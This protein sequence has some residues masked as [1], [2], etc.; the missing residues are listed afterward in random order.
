MFKSDLLDVLFRWFDRIL[1]GISAGLLCAS[2]LYSL[3]DQLARFAMLPMWLICTTTFIG[4]WSIRKL[5]DHFSIR[6]RRIALNPENPIDVKAWFRFPG[7]QLSV[8]IGVLVLSIF[9]VDL[10]LLT[11]EFLI[12]NSP[13]GGL[14]FFLAAGFI[15]ASCPSHEDLA[16][17]EPSC[18][19][20]SP[21]KLGACSD[22][23]FRR[24]VEQ[25][26]SE[27]G[28]DFYNRSAYIQRMVARLRDKSDSAGLRGQIL[29]GSFG[30]GKSTLLKHV[31]NN[32]QSEE[33]GTWLVSEFDCW[34]RSDEPH[35]LIRQLLSSV[36]SD[37]GSKVEATSLMTLPSDFMHAAYGVNS[38]V[39]FFYFLGRHHEPETVLIRL[40][41]LLSLQGLELLIIIEN[42]DRS[43]EFN[44][45]V[46][47]VAAMLDKAS[48]LSSIQFIFTGDQKSLPLPLVSRISDY[49]ESLSNKLDPE[50]IGRFFKLCLDHSFPREGKKPIIPYLPKNYSAT[51]GNGVLRDLKFKDD[52]EDISGLGHLNEQLLDAICILLGNPRQL[53]IVL[54][55]TYE[56]WR[57]LQGEVYIVDLLVYSVALHDGEILE[58]IQ[59][60]L[61]GEKI[62]NPFID[63]AKSK[64]RYYKNIDD[65]RDRIK[66]DS[67]HYRDIIAYYLASDPKGDVDFYSHFSV[68]NAQRIRLYGEGQDKYKYAVD[69]GHVDAYYSDQSI[70]KCLVG[71]SKGDE[72]IVIEFLEKLD[73]SKFDARTIIEE[74]NRRYW[75][76]ITPLLRVMES[77]TS[78][79]SIHDRNIVDILIVIID[80]VLN[81]NYSRDRED[82]PR[83]PSDFYAENATRTFDC[84]V[85]QLYSLVRRG[86]YFRFGMIVRDISCRDE[87]IK[88]DFSSRIVEEFTSPESHQ[89]WA[90][91]DMSD[92]GESQGLYYYLLS[93][94]IF[95]FD[96]NVNSKL[97]REIDLFIL[98]LLTLHKINSEHDIKK[99]LSGYGGELNRSVLDLPSR[100][101]EYGMLEPGE[102]SPEQQE[103]V[104]ALREYCS[105][106][107]RLDIG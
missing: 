103:E 68:Q 77:I 15:V 90:A 31:A 88:E 105:N 38:W 13:T 50:I 25:E 4:G 92:P 64:S 63:G 46:P 48:N 3:S 83:D 100:L 61:N 95:L 49:T 19:S 55:Y 8:V 29:Y 34:G 45:L 67:R 52:P 47:A 73:F 59:S 21:A 101:Q 57:T 33:P 35:E 62:A 17:A 40:N 69:T 1:L 10:S 79:D 39:R 37:I 24:W 41:K 18:S 9:A 53:K 87:F 107:T 11:G 70:L 89:L 16:E 32:L 106:F 12:L 94:N 28:M 75:D 72:N 43:P 65:D 91:T 44:E 6:F 98:N 2:A 82:I 81:S 104:R 66:L 71:I 97:K 20:P 54:R 30:S 85:V 22:G 7:S 27:E 51:S 76:D 42:I 93:L 36:V 56:R 102:L 86:D 84:L 14:A 23:E 99:F 26:K 5:A 74:M 78:C 58:R 60:L 96:P 80:V